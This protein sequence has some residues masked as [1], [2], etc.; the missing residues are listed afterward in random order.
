VGSEILSWFDCESTA[1]VNLS[2]LARAEGTPRVIWDTDEVPVV[3][4]KLSL[5]KVTPQL[6]VVIDLLTVTVQ[7]LEVQLV[8]ASAGL[9]SWVDN[10]ANSRSASTSAF[11]CRNHCAPWEFAKHPERLPTYLF[12]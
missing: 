4:V 2:R 10:S 1:W 3:R 11:I 6:L 12:P 5:T 8:R 9:G 7:L